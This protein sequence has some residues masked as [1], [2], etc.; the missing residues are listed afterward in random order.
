MSILRPDPVKVVQGETLVGRRPDGTYGSL[1]AA[2]NKP[3]WQDLGNGYMVDKNDPNGRAMPIPGGRAPVKLA[4]G[5]QLVGPNGPVAAVPVTPDYRPVPGTGTALN[6]RDGSSIALP[7][8]AGSSVHSIKVNGLDVPVMV[9]PNPNGGPP[10]VQMLTPGAAA[11]PGGTGQ[12]SGAGGPISFNGTPQSATPQGGLLDAIAPLVKQAGQMK[13]DESAQVK[14][15]D[16]QVAEQAKIAQAGRDARVKLA[17]LD[18]LEQLS[19]KFGNNI[20]TKVNAKLNEWGWPTQSGTDQDAFRGLIGALAVGERPAGSGS[21]RV[22]EMD[23]FKSNLGDA[24]MNQAGRIAAIN[25]YRTVLQRDAQIGDLAA[26]T[27]LSPGERATRIQTLSQQPYTP[28]GGTDGAGASASPGGAPT[29][30]A[31]PPQAVPAPSDALAQAQ[32]AIARGAPRA[33]VIQR[34]QAAGIN[35]AGL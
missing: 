16:T 35:P 9:T 19:G 25:R 32:A 22:A 3:D 30:S 6:S 14:E 15:A 34:L 7:G 5:D 31:A 17:Q 28:V 33:A 11:G 12:P 8:G 21:L 27:T 20:G 10:Q 24:S 29:A 2:P 4:P 23:A 26:D 1:Y 13:A 18:Q